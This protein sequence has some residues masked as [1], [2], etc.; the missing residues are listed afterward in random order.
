MSAPSTLLPPRGTRVVV[1]MS[2]GVDS[3]VAAALLVEQG[4]EVVG[5][6]LRLAEERPGGTSSGCCSLEDFQDAARVADSLGVPHYV[7]DMR[8]AFARDVIG[9]FVEEYLAGR[10]PSPCIL[11]NRSIKF[12]ALRRRAAELGAQWVATG[13]YARRDF[14]SAHFR[15]RTGLDSTKD[16]S[17]FLFEM[18]QAGLAHTLFPVGDMTKDGVRAYAASRG[19]VTAGKADSQEI[20]FVPDG[21]YA[22]FV[23]KVAPGRTRSGP[24][25]NEAG[26]VIGTHDG[27]HRYTVGQ[28]RGLGIA[29]SEPLY[30]EA[31]H[32]DSATV[33]VAPRASLRRAGLVADGAVWTSGRPERVGVRFDARIR[34]RHRATPVTLLHAVDGVLE[35]KFDDPQEAVTPG[36]AVVFYRGDVVV[37]GA[38]IRESVPLVAGEHGAQVTRDASGPGHAQCANHTDPA[39]PTDAV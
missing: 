39:T 17:Y 9:P 1:A 4:Y 20:C 12:S 37:G 28:R 24:V 26:D 5:I 31:V 15:L 11:C 21:R 2:G 30:V 27:V 8:E 32:A 3:S 22:E 35:L 6:S 34:Y 23:E 29:H 7:F 13:H 10:T 19:I 33:R 18:D 25:V 36:Q 16:Q 14:H 38:W